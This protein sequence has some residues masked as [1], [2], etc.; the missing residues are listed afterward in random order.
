MSYEFL[1]HDNRTCYECDDWPTFDCAYNY[2]KH[3]EIIHNTFKLKNRAIIS[4]DGEEYEME[5]YLV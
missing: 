2:D 5:V 3:M 4:L 1:D